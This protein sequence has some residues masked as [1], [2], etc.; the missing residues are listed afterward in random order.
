MGDLTRVTV[1]FPTSH[2]IFPSLI[3]AILGL[4]GLAI[5]L[6]RHRAILGAPTYWAGVVRVMDKRRFL[7]TLALVVIYFASL[8]PLGNL[9]P[10]RGFGFLFASIPFLF[11]NGLVLLRQRNARAL[12]V[13]ALISILAPLLSWWLFSEI[14]FLTLP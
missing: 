9:W 12:A 2:L 13:L 4:L 10:N 14:F 3:G 11:L 7:G 1:D 5:L 8:E 6:T